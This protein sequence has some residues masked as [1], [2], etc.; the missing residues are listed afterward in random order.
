MAKALSHETVSGYS[1]H[2]TAEASEKPLPSGSKWE[3][4]QRLTTR[5]WAE[6]ERDF[7]A[8][9]P[10]VAIFVQTLPSKHSALCREGAKRVK[11]AEAVDD[12]KETEFSRPTR[13]DAHLNLC[14]RPAQALSR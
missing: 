3:P 4:M 10:K 6:R 14:I 11:E 8:L 2:T 5:Q 9:T 7:S 1:N 13:T 12:S